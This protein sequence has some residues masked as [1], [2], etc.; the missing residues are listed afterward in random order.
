MEIPDVGLFKVQFF[1][2]WPEMDLRLLS[3]TV[4]GHMGKDT[5]IHFIRSF[6]S[7]FF[8]KEK[9]QDSVNSIWLECDD[10]WSINKIVSTEY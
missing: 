8:L 4:T 3:G 1:R 5:A 7:L 2:H 6:L 10:S 9:T